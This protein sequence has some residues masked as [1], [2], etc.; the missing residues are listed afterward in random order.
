MG[1]SSV[2]AAETLAHH[3]CCAYAGTVGLCQGMWEVEYDLLPRAWWL[4]TWPRRV[5][6]VFFSQLALAIVV[7][8]GAIVTFVL[9]VGEGNGSAAVVVFSLC[10]AIVVVSIFLVSFSMHRHTSGVVRY[11]AKRVCRWRWWWLEFVEHC[12]H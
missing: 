5:V 7:V 1:H 10:Y 4:L 12:C 3:P 6:C 8:L 9:W 11:Y 2:L